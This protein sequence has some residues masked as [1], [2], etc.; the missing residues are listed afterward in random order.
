MAKAI[1]ATG[2]SG[3]INVVLCVPRRLRKYEKPTVGSNQINGQLVV[4]GN[5]RNKRKESKQSTPSRSS[6]LDPRP[7][8]TAENEN[9]NRVYH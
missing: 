2:S 9:Q 3:N 5:E 1:F 4:P 6:R 8:N 7:N